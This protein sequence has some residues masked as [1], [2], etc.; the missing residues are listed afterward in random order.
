VREIGRLLFTLASMT[1]ALAC[2]LVLAL[3]ATLEHAGPAGQAFVL[4]GRREL[5]LDR[6]AAELVRVTHVPFRVG[7][8]Q[9]PGKDA[10]PVVGQL[11][12]IERI[13][14]VPFW[15]VA[16]GAMAL[17]LCWAAAACHRMRVDSLIRRGLCARCKY[18]LRASAERCPECGL[19]IP[20][21]GVG[22]PHGAALA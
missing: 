12:T 10:T 19:P 17:P 7:T 2:L 22:P 15:A 16:A 20:R 4:S 18:D 1:S 8:Q 14:R 11:V 5:R 9:L 3:W 6:D 13:R 21:R